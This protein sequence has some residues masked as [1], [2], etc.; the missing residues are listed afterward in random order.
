MKQI[1]IAIFLLLLGSISHAATEG[2]LTFGW[3]PETQEAITNQGI[4][5]LRVYQD[6]SANKVGSATPLAG[7]ITLTTAI[8]DCSNFWATYATI[9][10][11]S[12]RTDPPIKV[13]EPSLADPLPATQIIQV[14]GF[15]LQV[16]FTPVQNN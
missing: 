10:D 13:C 1:L 4:T 6:S 14:G 9:D 15:K 3:T 5:E 11:E 7:T 12:E 2:T 8:T 16:E